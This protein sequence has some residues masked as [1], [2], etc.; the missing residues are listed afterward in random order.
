MG[1]TF[2]I[3]RPR[4][5]QNSDY[6]DFEYLMRWIGRDGSDYLYMFYDVEM[7]RKTHGEVINSE[8]STRIETLISKESQAITLQADDLSRSDLAII[9]QIFS[10]KFVTRLF[11][12]GTTERYAPQ[13][14]SYKYRLMDG[15]YE[16]EIKF[17]K[18]DL[19]AWN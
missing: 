16:V 15:R 11:K 8:S 12:D 4:S 17:T 6:E 18:S 7:E 9:L 2:Q 10:N 13:P 14:N 1:K 3:I 5:L 19:A